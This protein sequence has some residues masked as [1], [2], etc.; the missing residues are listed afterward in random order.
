MTSSLFF[1]GGIDVDHPARRYDVDECSLHYW[2][3]RDIR[4]RWPV[5]TRA[6]ENLPVQEEVEEND[7]W[8]EDH[9]WSDGEN[10]WSAE[11][12]EDEDEGNDAEDV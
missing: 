4:E 12:S 1:S 9:P 8:E 3:G 11:V 7:D 6:L 10:E 5:F 2:G